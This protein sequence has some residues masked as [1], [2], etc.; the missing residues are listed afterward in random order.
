MDQLIKLLQE[1]RL[2]AIKNGDGLYGDLQMA[3]KDI[4]ILLQSSDISKEK[5]K[6]LIAPTGNLQD[7]SIDCGWGEKY[8]D[9]AEM[10]ENI[11]L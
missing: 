3:V 7:L 10:I 11:K 8:C 9:L 1:I 2:L 6:L 5:L 4:D